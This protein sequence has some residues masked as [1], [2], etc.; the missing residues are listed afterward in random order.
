[1]KKTKKIKVT[2][3]KSQ[4]DDWVHGPWRFGEGGWVKREEKTIQV[5]E[6]KRKEKSL[7]AK[8]T[9]GDIDDAFDT[10]S[11]HFLELISK[12]MSES[13]FVPDILEDDQLVM[14]E[15]LDDCDDYADSEVDE[16]VDSDSDVV[17]E[18]TVTAPIAAP[19]SSSDERNKRLSELKERMS[20]K[21]TWK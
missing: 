5:K 1:M 14:I 4:G 20:N 16:A 19:T 13:D 12:S 10:F 15:D 11:D 21:K 3:D 6:V 8:E 2:K 17:E 9:S 18:P 7:Q